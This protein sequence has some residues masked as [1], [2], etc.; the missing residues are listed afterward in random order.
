M[1]AFKDQ[2]LA[3]KASR[4]ESAECGAVMLLGAK[5]DGLTYSRFTTNSQSDLG[6]QAAI[7]VKGGARRWPERLRV[8]QP[9]SHLTAAQVER[10][11]GLYLRPGRK[12]IRLIS[13]AG[14]SMGV[15][16]FQ[17]V[18]MGRR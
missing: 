7:V 11:C 14:S 15:S 9:G 3:R 8:G 17:P 2:P 4:S 13:A 16:A 18:L 10:R 5:V 12:S 1:R 6:A